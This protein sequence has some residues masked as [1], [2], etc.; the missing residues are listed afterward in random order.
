MKVSQVIERYELFCPQDLSLEGDISG[1]Q[2]GSLDQEVRRVMVALD[3]RETT[4]MEAIAAK[5]DLLIVNQARHC[6]LRFSHQH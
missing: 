2:I 3:V 1:L 5:V 6:C 4:V